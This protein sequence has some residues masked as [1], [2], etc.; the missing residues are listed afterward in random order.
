MESVE[1]AKFGLGR[2]VAT[3]GAVS[4][5]EEARDTALAY[6]RRHESG[7]WGDVPPEDRE[8]N[9]FSIKNGFRLLSSYKLMDETK[10]WIIT[11]ADRSMTTILLPEEY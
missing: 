5:L 6:L 11:E 3:P 7:D 10:I 8:E 4:A 2:V 1:K 9:E